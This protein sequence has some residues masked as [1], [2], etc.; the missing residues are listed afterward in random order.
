MG[1]SETEKPDAAAPRVAAAPGLARLLGR[2]VFCGLLSP[3][4]LTALPYG[5]VEPWWQSLF[6][7]ARG[8]KGRLVCKKLPFG[9][10]DPA[11]GRAYTWAAY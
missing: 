1:A 2:A 9:H 3:L 4:V 7:P 5:A 8:E 11:G 10:I 6:G